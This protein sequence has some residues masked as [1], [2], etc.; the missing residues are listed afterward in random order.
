MPQIDYSLLTLAVAT[1]SLILLLIEL[2]SNHVWNQKRTSYELMNETINSGHLTGAMDQLQASFDWD[3]LAGR[4]T[5]SDVVARLKPDA[6]H[7]QALDQPLVVILR[8][9][10]MVSISMVHGIIDERIVQDSMLYF[11]DKIY[12]AARPFIDSERVRRGETEVYVNFE[13]YALKWR[14]A[15]PTH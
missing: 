5:Y 9:L 8:H 13:R 14:G 4:E 12:S 3:L 6:R 7:R 11:F 15:T 2:R 1:G 10:E